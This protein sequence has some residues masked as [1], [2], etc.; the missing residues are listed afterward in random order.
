MGGG[1]QREAHVSVVQARGAEKV[2]GC[3]RGQNSQPS[4]GSWRRARQEL[5]PPPP[6][7]ESEQGWADPS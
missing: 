3:L 2:A 1:E 7:S 6:P 4:G 5:R